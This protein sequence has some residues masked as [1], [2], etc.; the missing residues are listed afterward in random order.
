[1]WQSHDP[2]WDGFD[3][4]AD[5]ED[6]L[7]LGSL[8]KNPR[9]KQ[10]SGYNEKRITSFMRRCKERGVK[11]H[12]LGYAKEQHLAKFRPTTCDSSSQ[13]GSA[14]FGSPLKI[15]SPDGCRV[16]VILDYNTGPKTT[17]E[18]NAVQ[19]ILPEYEYSDWSRSRHMLAFATHLLRYAACE[20]SFGTHI[21]SAVSAKARLDNW[22]EAYARTKHLREA[23]R[24]RTIRTKPSS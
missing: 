9:M 19:A 3:E 20:V 4:F 14:R 24:C 13:Q 5:G 15:Y 21:Y 23:I 7:S 10:P 8:V 6:W 1:V 12:L 11:T 2:S 16:E 22:R 18:I 17:A